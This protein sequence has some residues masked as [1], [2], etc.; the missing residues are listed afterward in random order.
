MADKNYK[1]KEKSGHNVL[2]CTGH[3]I[4]QTISEKPLLLTMSDSYLGFYGAANKKQENEWINNIVLETCPFF[5]KICWKNSILS[6]FVESLLI[7]IL[8]RKP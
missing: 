6:E 5:E 4:A 8:R 7:K 2:F 1:C 3:Q